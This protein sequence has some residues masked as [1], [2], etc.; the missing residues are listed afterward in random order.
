MYIGNLQT[1]QT[2][3]NPSK[4]GGCRAGHKNTRPPTSPN[5][6]RGGGC[7]EG[8]KDLRPPLAPP[9]EGDAESTKRPPLTPPEEGNSESTKSKN[10]Y[11]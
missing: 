4:G 3:P 9:R 7:R 1:L 11:I 10:D 8:Y 5:P 6:S 2:S